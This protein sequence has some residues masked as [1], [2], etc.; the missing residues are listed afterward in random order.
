MFS[1]II[2][3]SFQREVDRMTF[4]DFK[5]SNPECNQV[6]E[7]SK[8]TVN[9]DWS[10]KERVCPKCGAKCERVFALMAT[11]VAAGTH[12]NAKTGYEKQITYHPSRFK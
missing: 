7:F 1:V 9:E 8:P 5:C 11:D 4:A 2:L 3:K 6:T 12:G 10:S